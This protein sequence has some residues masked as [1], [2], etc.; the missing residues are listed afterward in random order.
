MKFGPVPAGEA[1][2]TILAHSTRLE[3]R[4]IKKGTVLSA[5]DIAAITD[6]GIEQ[7]TVAALDAGDVT[8]DEAAAAITDALTGPG[9][10]AGRAFTGRC[11]LI[12]DAH[13]VLAFEREILDRLNLVS[14][15]VTVATAPAYEVVGEGQLVATI[16]IIPFAISAAVLDAVMAVAKSGSP[17]ISVAPFR[18]RKTGLILTRL[19]GMKESILDNTVKTAAARIEAYGSSITR[20]IRCE[21]DQ[22]Q[23][24]SAIKEIADDGCEMVFIFGASAVVDR[25]DVLPAAVV[26]AG[27]R[28]DH[29]GMPVDPGNLLFIGSALDRPVVGMPGCARSPKLNGF[30]WVLWRLLAGIEVTAR[31]IM[32]MGPGGLLKEISE[33]GQ[34]RANQNGA[35]AG[36][37]EPRIGA[38]ILAAGSSRRM[39]AENKLLA[40]VGGQPMVSHIARAV[41]AADV[42]AVTVVTGHEAELVKAALDETD[43]AANYVH[44]PDYGRG[45]STSLRTGVAALADDLDGVV[46]CLGDM[47]LVST[48]DIN[49]LIRAFDPVEGRAICVPVSG[50]KRGNPVLWAKS[51]LAEMAAISGDVGARHL[52]EQHAEQ[53]FEVPVSGEGVLMDIDTPERLAELRTR[54]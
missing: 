40:G 6:A 7:I 12:A 29:F 41:A 47:P 31:D 51:F 38:L 35:K 3:G 28:V 43:L 32:L 18:P 8:E 37:H 44:N 26:E 13:G 16:K 46:I 14:E 4:I 24:A 27:G 54:K 9:I 17:M 33:R 1:V 53:I 10:H 2:G 52:L 15:S 20:V 21:H 23:V 42:A 36:A 49:K 45:L 48:D 5:D 34:L 30:D 39:G 19:P 25:Q 11:N 50:R 22:G